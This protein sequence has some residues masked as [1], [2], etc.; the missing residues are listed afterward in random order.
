MSIM[1]LDGDK[2]SVEAVR[3]LERS[4]SMGS[5]D[6]S[7]GWRVVIVD[8]AHNMTPRAIQ[9]WLTLLERIPARRLIVFTSTRLGDDLFGDSEFF[10]PFSG[11]V[12]TFKLTNQ[13]LCEPF[14]R[15]V[16]GIARRE[17]LDGKPIEAYLKLAKECGNSCRAMLQA[18]EE[19]AMLT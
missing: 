5:L 4:L 16:A 17:H 8:E 10:K 15:L 2:C 6:S 11:R 9:A 19:R 14:A 18:V 13:G 1:M 7:E 3:D 12:K